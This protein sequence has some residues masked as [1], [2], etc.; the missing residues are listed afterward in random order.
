MTLLVGNGEPV[1]VTEQKGAFGRIAFRKFISRWTADGGE[2]TQR[3][4]R[5]EEAVSILAG[6]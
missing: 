2:E 1:K 6:F 4:V 5:E 3:L